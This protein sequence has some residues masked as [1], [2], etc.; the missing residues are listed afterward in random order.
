[1]L[2]RI[3]L[4]SFCVLRFWEETTSRTRDG[5]SLLDTLYLNELGLVI[6][7]FAAAS[8]LEC[9]FLSPT[10]RKSS[11]SSELYEVTRPELS[12]RCDLR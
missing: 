4:R 8:P 2:E 9:L 6:D 5:L 12:E 10:R 1:M 3:R 7:L 11:L